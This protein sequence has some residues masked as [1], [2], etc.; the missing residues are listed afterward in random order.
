[1]NKIKELEDVPAFARRGVNLDEVPHSSENNVSRFSVDSFEVD[2]EQRPEIRRNNG[3][4]NDN[5]D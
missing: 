3:Y 5:V 4:L 1:M 2:G